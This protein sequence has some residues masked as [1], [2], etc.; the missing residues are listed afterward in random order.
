MFNIFDGLLDPFREAIKNLLLNNNGIFDITGNNTTIVSDSVTVTPDQV[1]GN[2]AWNNIITWS[3]LTLM[4]IALTLIGV[5]FAMEMYSLL[6]KSQGGTDIEDIC[7]V[8]FRIMIPIFFVTNASRFIIII[9]KLLN[10]YVLRLSNLVNNSAAATPDYTELI[11]TIDNMGL[12][13]LISALFTYGLI[14]MIISLVVPIILLFVV[15][16]RLFEIIFLIFGAPIPMATFVSSEWSSVGR[17]YI[18]YFVSLIIQGMMIVLCCGIFDALA[19]TTIIQMGSNAAILSS[20]VL[21]FIIF[22]TGKV[23]KQLVNAF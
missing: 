11:N 12:G 2:A 17:A 3:D 22:R 13:E 16:G 14:G 1:I 18:K 21:A 19:T 23:S 6:G 7:K 8:L 15:Y 5:F 20:L 4:P 10:S 9:M